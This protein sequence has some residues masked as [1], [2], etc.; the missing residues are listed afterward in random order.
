LSVALNRYS[1]SEE[2]RM[3]NTEGEEVIPVPTAMHMAVP[4]S[5]R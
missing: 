3:K 5:L 1:V 2:E 4:F